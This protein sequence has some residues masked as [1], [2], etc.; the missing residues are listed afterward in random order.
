MEV[1]PTTA[2]P[3]FFALWYESINGLWAPQVDGLSDKTTVLF[4]QITIHES[5][6]PMDDILRAIRAKTGVRRLWIKEWLGRSFVAMGLEDAP[7]VMKVMNALN[8]THAVQPHPGFPVTFPKGSTIT[9]ATMEKELEIGYNQLLRSFGNKYTAASCMGFVWNRTPVEKYFL[10]WNYATP[11]GKAFC[12]RLRQEFD[13]EPDVDMEDLTRRRASDCRYLQPSFLQACQDAQILHC[14]QEYGFVPSLNTVEQHLVLPRECER[15]H[16]ETKEGAQPEPV[17]DALR[18]SD[19]PSS[20]VEEPP[21]C[22]LCLSAL[23]KTMV[24][25]CMHKSVCKG[26]SASLARSD[27]RYRCICIQCRQP[28]Q[29]IIEDSVLTQI[30]P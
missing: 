20:R 3:A 12:R 27:T 17:E 22:V 21:T 13:L 7:M 6:G 24:L 28:F 30:L 19:F 14:H 1:T 2:G 5:D 26:C 10:P 9:R 25:P 8:E 11:H 29:C 15:D 23:A 16:E 4:A 18:P